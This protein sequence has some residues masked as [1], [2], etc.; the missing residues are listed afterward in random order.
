MEESGILRSFAY[1][2]FSQAKSTDA[3]ILLIL[4]VVG[5]ASAL[6]MN[7]TS[8]IIFTPVMLMLAL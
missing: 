6:L 2:I 5:G 3:L 7:D 8:A 1:E 4:F